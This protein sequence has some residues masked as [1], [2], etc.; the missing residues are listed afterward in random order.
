MNVPVEYNNGVKRRCT[1]PLLLSKVDVGRIS[2]Q[3]NELLEK[4]AIK[5]CIEDLKTVP[6]SHQAKKPM[7]HRRNVLGG[8]NSSDSGT[9]VRY[10]RECTTGTEYPTLMKFL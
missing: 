1:P 6:I 4:I 5:K 2:D 8:H 10:D 7:K 9:R 3:D